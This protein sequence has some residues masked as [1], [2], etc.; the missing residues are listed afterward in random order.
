MEPG[1]GFAMYMPWGSSEE[2][3]AQLGREKIRWIKN[4]IEI[5]GETHP[6][7]KVSEPGVTDLKIPLP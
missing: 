7:L 1:P 2:N 6:E 5:V 3:L 4:I